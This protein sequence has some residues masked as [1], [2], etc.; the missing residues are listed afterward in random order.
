MLSDCRINEFYMRFCLIIT[1]IVKKLMIMNRVFHEFMLMNLQ[2]LD[3]KITD[4][5]A[6]V[7]R[8]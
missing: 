3:L 4:P 2:Q 7:P 6:F 1:C 5:I 8:E